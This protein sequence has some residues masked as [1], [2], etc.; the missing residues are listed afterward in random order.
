M[1]I[2]NPNVLKRFN[3]EIAMSTICCTCKFCAQSHVAIATRVL[4]DLITIL[5]AAF[6]DP[7]ST[8]DID[9]R[10]I[11]AFRKI[12]LGNNTEIHLIYMLPK[13]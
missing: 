6:R 9:Y 7:F 5:K 13:N 1:T 11:K 10:K 4:D 8:L 2:D 3:Y 12:L